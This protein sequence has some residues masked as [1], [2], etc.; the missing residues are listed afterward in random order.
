[1]NAAIIKTVKLVNMI[2]R[3][4]RHTR[5]VIDHLRDDL[6]LAMRG[7]LSLNLLGIDDL[8]NIL[9]DIRSHIPRTLRLPSVHD[10]KLIWY[11]KH[12]P[13]TVLADINKL[14]VLLFISLIH[15]NAIL[16]IYEVITIPVPITNTSR[17]SEIEVESNFIAISA[18][19]EFYSILS[20]KEAIQ[21][22]HFEIG[23]CAVRN[24]PVNI[25]GIPSCLSSIFV[26]NQELIT[27]YCKINIINNPILPQLKHL[28][29]G[30]WLFATN[31]SLDI[32][33]DC[34]SLN[35][36]L[37]HIIA[38]GPLD[39]IKIPEGCFGHS[40]HAYLLSYFHTISSKEKHLNTD[41]IN[42]DWHLDHI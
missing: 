26:G 15:T 13:T 23:Y 41:K 36:S 16:T 30:H 39:I 20:G 21:C 29:E 12:T 34:P 1:M 40:K 19:S 38:E 7:Q 11:Y 27:K 10:H 14:H 4:L 3:T 18:D 24:A 2:T 32:S 22:P 25:T 5:R 35:Y 33:L 42:F 31:E 28:D 8:Q 9:N 37:T 17:A 6:F